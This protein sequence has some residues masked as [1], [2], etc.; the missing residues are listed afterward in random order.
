MYLDS[1]YVP[2]YSFVRKTL[3]HRQLLFSIVKCMINQRRIDIIKSIYE[4]M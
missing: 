4:I 3:T 1:R 2:I